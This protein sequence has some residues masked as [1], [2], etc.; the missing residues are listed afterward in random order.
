VPLSPLGGSI[1][2]FD[3]GQA[4]ASTAR[5][6]RELLPATSLEQA[7]ELLHGL[8]VRTEL[9]YELANAEPRAEG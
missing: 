6:A 9:D 5:L 3:P 7:N 4:L 8:G 1:V 2:Y